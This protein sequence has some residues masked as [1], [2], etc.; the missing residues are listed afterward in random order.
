MAVKNYFVLTFLLAGINQLMTAQTPEYLFK[1]TLPITAD[2]NY[3]PFY[4]DEQMI[5][6][7]Y[8]GHWD[9]E[10]DFHEK[11][12]PRALHYS[13]VLQPPHSNVYLFRNRSGK[14]IKAFNTTETLEELTR[15]FSKIPI[16][17][18]SRTIHAFFP[19]HAGKET[20]A[21]GA[22]IYSSIW[23][24]RFNG[25][26]K[27]YDMS[28]PGSLVGL[29]DS[30]GDI[31]VPVEYE[32]IYFL[33]NN[34]LIK[35][36]GKWGIIDKQVRNILPP[37]YD[38][39]NFESE[40]I[41]CFTRGEKLVIVYSTATAK[42]KALD[43]YDEI[44]NIDQLQQYGVTAFKKDQKIGFIDKHYKEIVPAIY[45]MVG[46][47]YPS[48]NKNPTLVCR[49]GKWG[50]IN[51]AAKEVIPCKYD[52][53]DRFDEA[54]IALV[55]HKN[56]W[57]C[58][59]KEGKKQAACNKKP[60]WEPFEYGNTDELQV[61]KNM[62]GIGDYYGL[63]N[64]K[65]NKLVLPLIYD[66]INGD[67][68]YNN[69]FRVERDKKWGLANAEGKFL[70]DCE[71]EEIGQ[72]DREFAVVKK[73]GLAGVINR[74]LKLVIPCIYQEIQ[75]HS[76]NRFVF[77]LNDKMGLMDS[78][79]N[80]IIPNRYDQFYGFHQL[81]DHEHATGLSMVMNDSLYG[82]INLRGEEVIPVKFKWLD[83]KIYSG[84]V[85]FGENGKYGFLDTAGT[86]IIPAA[87]D[88]V[89]GF[90][91][92]IAG[93]EKEKKWAFIDTNGTLITPFIYDLIVGHT[94]MDKKYMVV[95][96]NGKHGVVN[97]AGKEIIPCKYDYIKSFTNGY[98]YVQ[99][100]SKQ[101]RIN[102]A[103]VESP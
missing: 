40:D 58:I 43:E 81:N 37:E 14:I 103:G 42:L 78:L 59:N 85:A 86:V 68:Y 90:E 88:R 76:D 57:I 89:W 15:Q 102:E 21:N 53:A 1:P 44:I 39:Y 13:M 17:Q 6:L 38:G 11:T 34:L 12:R 97:T 23:T 47:Y 99:S 95:V 87:Y 72:I 32:E 29:I 36:K 80:V 54:G 77:R 50:Y 16:N 64:R 56:K 30:L 5:E 33:K 9:K 100:G 91:K 10:V 41:I 55:Q 26:Y 20:L 73:K 69:I 31:R 46:E 75:G 60:N 79:Q 82:Y 7:D 48:L 8:I 52:Y 18:K 51:A 94:W 63:I 62:N 65:N 70:L 24:H 96:K 71:Y 25:F 93:I 35:K 49:N 67:L 92:S 4:N 45:D 27:I 66:Y 22:W 3:Y 84:L 83:Y 98:F 2:T 101:L 61:V 28:Q 19:W 74:D